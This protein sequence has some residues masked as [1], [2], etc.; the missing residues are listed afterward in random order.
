MDKAENKALA[1]TKETV[2]KTHTT[3]KNTKKAKEIEDSNK[4]SAMFVTN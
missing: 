1:H 3:E 4:R 2:Q